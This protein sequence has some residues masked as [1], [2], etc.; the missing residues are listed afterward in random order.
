[1]YIFK[2]GC[3]YYCLLFYVLF[4]EYDGDVFS[5]FGVE[6]GESI[7]MLIVFL[8]LSVFVYC[9]IMGRIYYS[10]R[11]NVEYWQDFLF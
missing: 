1:M 2:V 4:Q 7:V 11:G 9:I 5:D 8:S 3:L 6:D 10:E